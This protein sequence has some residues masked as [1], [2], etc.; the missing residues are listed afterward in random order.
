MKI[1]VTG[2]AGFIG[3]HVCKKLIEANKYQVFGIDNI[4][5]YYDIK[6][7]KKRLKLLNKSKKKFKFIKLN[8]LNKK[9]LFQNFKTKKF[10]IVIHLAAQAGVRFSIDNPQSYVDSNLVGFFNIIDCS[11]LFKIK[12]FV[13]ASTSSVYG[14]TKKFPINESAAT[15]KPLSF[16][17]ATKKCNEV[18]AYSYSNIYNLPSTG[19][20]F[21]TV[22]GP[23]G[24]PDMAL[25][26]F[27]KN[28][29][30]NKKIELYNNGKH[31]RDWTYV[32][33]TVNAVLAIMNKPSSSVIPYSIYNVGSNKPNKLKVFLNF[34]EGSLKK[35]AKIQNM[36]L[37]QGDVMMTHADNSAIIKKTKIKFSVDIKT[38]I[39]NFISWYKKYYS[40]KKK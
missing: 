16:Y 35:K 7:K 29:L 33:D 19:L 14:D 36:K 37:Q 24:R 1:L 20:R 10:D 31:T 15:D 28:I 40:D 13:F 9:K 18:I 39:Q 25:F 8:I 3:Y 38:G 26:K 27:T 17:A 21:F 34:I 30:Q 11:R 5:N 6:L 23:L 32:D 2:C 12:H 4:N 22:Y